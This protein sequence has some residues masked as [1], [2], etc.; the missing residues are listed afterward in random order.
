LER[1]VTATASIA[2]HLAH[3]GFQVRLVSADTAAD[4]HEHADL[5]WHDGDVAAHI[6]PVLER[7]AAL[8]TSPATELDS[9]WT[10]ETAT[11]GSFIGVFGALSDHDRARL[12]RIHLHGGTSYAL[13]VDVGSWTAR[14]ERGGASASTTWMHQRG[15]KASELTRTGSLQAAWQEL[16]R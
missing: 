13:V 11:P 16:G 3:A 1:A 7:L 8:P 2:V 5:S 15:W 6:G 9:V 14:G 4:P 10:D 12:A